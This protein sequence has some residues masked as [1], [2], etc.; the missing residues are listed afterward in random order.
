MADKLF[1]ADR[2]HDVGILKCRPSNLNH[3]VHHTLNSSCGRHRKVF[4][5]L[6]TELLGYCALCSQYHPKSRNRHLL[7][8]AFWGT[9]LYMLHYCPQ[10]L[11]LS[12]ERCRR[13]LDRTWN[14]DRWR[15]RCFGCILEGGIIL[16][17]VRF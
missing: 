12:Q 4:A 7:E 6:L 17:K 1:S 13:A 14:N 9:K 3:L 16:I 10:T 2:S 5:P 11:R 8:I 15:G